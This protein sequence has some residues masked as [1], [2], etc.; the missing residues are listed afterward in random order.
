MNRCW[1]LALILSLAW[2]TTAEATSVKRLDQAGLVRHARTIF[3]GDVVSIRTE[4]NKARTCIFTVVTFAPREVLKGTRQA[5]VTLKLPGGA[6]DGKATI[7]RGVPRFKV[8]QEV[9]VFASGRHKK[10]GVCYPVGLGQ[11]LYRIDRRGRTGPRVRRDTRAL[12][13]VELR[14]G[15]KPKVTRGK[16]EVGKLDPLLEAI[17]AEVAK[18]R[19]K[20]A[21]DKQAQG[22]RAK[23][24]RAKGK[25]QGGR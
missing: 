14:K 5:L 20:Q 18:Q 21:K 16:L 25:K 22:K 11:G 24:K 19:A 13:I 7:V 3:H 6:K 1:S 8:G 17:R 4:W 15:K 10:S 12:R 9:V 23:G 2:L